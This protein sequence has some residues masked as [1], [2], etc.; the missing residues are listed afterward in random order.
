[1]GISDAPVWDVA[2]GVLVLARN[3]LPT[4]ERVRLAPGK[5]N[6][7]RTGEGV[8]PATM[9]R[10]STSL[11]RLCR[12]LREMRAN[13]SGVLSRRRLAAK[14]KKRAPIACF[15]ASWAMRGWRRWRQQ[16]GRTRSRPRRCLRCWLSVRRDCGARPPWTGCV[17]GCAPTLPLPSQPLAAASVVLTRARSPC[18][19]VKEDRARDVRISECRDIDPPFPGAEISCMAVDEVEDR[20]LVGRACRTGQDRARACPPLTP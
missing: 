8:R 15:A 2:V 13:M 16:H 6:G 17:W 18:Q 19:L 9:R 11:H 5:A 20:S 3:A 7:T 1:V 10:R 12:C 4:L 14:Q